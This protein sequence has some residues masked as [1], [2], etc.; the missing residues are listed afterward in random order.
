[1]GMLPLIGTCHL[2]RTSTGIGHLDTNGAHLGNVELRLSGLPAEY[3]TNTS[4]SGTSVLVRTDGTVS[5]DWGAGAPDPVVPTNNFS[6]RWTGFIRGLEEGDHT[7]FVSA[8]A[9][10]GFRLRVN[11]QTVIDNWNNPNPNEVELGATNW[12]STQDTSIVLEYK[13]FTGEARIKLSWIPPGATNKAVIPRTHLRGPDLGTPGPTG[14]SVDAAGKIWAANWN[15]NTA[16]RIDPQDGVAVLAT[17]VTG[18]VTN[19]TTHRLGLVDMVVDLGDG[20]GHPSPYNQPATPYNYSDMTGFNNRIVNPGLKPLRGYWTVVNDSG[21]AGQLWNKV[22]WSNSIVSGCSVEVHVRAADDRPDLGRA[23]FV[24][25]TNGVSF[26]SIRG[27]YCEVRVGMTRDDG[28]KQ[29]VLYD[30]TLY[31]VSSGFAGT[32]FLYGAWADEGGDATFWTDLVGAGPVGYRWFR[33]WPWETNL[34]EVIGQT[35]WFLSITNVDSWVNGY[36][37]E[38][39]VFHRTMAACL[40][41]NGNG[42]SLWLGPQYLSVDWV[43]ADIPNSTVYANLMG[44][45]ERYPMTIYVFGMPTNFNNLSVKIMLKG[46]SHNRSADLDI[47]L[48]S[49]SGTQTMLMSNVGG[50]NGVSNATLSFQQVDQQPPQSAA[51]P[52]NGASS[53]GPSN[54]GSVSQMPQVGPDPPRNHFGPYP[55]NLSDVQYDN[56]NGRWKLYIYDKVLGMKGSLDSSWELEFKFQ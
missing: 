8:D 29:P 18:G 38:N 31:G 44:P 5:F 14:V 25:V 27:R 9:G 30:L 10:A 43:Q 33:Q 23:T 45:A 47:L 24:Q 15:N 42:E 4:L 40:V 19:I 12:L 48:V 52:S 37:D 34:T 11:D 2:A 21:N 32:D 56:P 55:A 49:P 1:M 46:L 22:S 17:N 51:I 28:S 16:M 36:V 20:S 13:E 41:T 39:D 35:N 26:L 53:C 54:Y 50:T 3:F 7:L 6:V